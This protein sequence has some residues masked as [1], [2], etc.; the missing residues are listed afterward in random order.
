MIE[1]IFWFLYAWVIVFCFRSIMVNSAKIMAERITVAELKMIIKKEIDD[2][3]KHTAV[4]DF[5]DDTKFVFSPYFFDKWTPMQFIRFAIEKRIEAG[6]D[7][8]F[9]NADKYYNVL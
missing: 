5:F 6:K 2:V 4:S 7:I 9:K 8:I 3:E 1:N